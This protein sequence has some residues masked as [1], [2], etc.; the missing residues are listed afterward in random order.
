MPKTYE[1]DEVEA[2][3]VEEYRSK[4]KS[5][6]PADPKTEAP[7]KAEA[8]D[9]EDQAPAQAPKETEGFE[10]CCSSCK[11]EF[12]GQPEKCPNCDEPLEWSSE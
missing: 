6:T 2:N 10:Y 11:H 1:L 12:N 5:K 8:L 4:K 7:K 9:I 3:A